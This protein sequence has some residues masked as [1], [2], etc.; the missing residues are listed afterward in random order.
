MLFHSD[1]LFSQSDAT[2]KEK[3]FQFSVTPGLGTN[4]MQPGSFS[5][6]ISINFTS[7]YSASTR[8]FEIGLVSN[9]NT[10]HTSG[11]QISGLANLTGANAFGGLSKK[12]KDMKLKNGFTS[13]LTGAQ[14]SGLTNIVVNDA[15]GAQFTGG[16]NLV[17]GLLL[18]TQISALSNIVYNYTFGVQAAGLFNVSVNSMD[19]VQISGLSNFTKGGLYGLQIGM[20]NQAGEMEGKNS[21]DNH[22]PTGIQF[23]LINFAKKMNGLQVGLINFAKR[24]QGT[25]IGLINFY[26]RGSQQ[27]TKDG[28]AIGLLN[29]GDFGYTSIYTN[30][31]F[32]LNYELATGTRK[33]TRI[34]LDSRNVYIENAL[35]YSRQAFHNDGWGIG[36]S[37]KKMFFNRSELLGATES[38]FYSYGLDIQHISLK[39]GEFNK[40]LSLLTRLKIM[41]GKRIAPKTFGINW[42]AAITYNAYWSNKLN[43][44]E[45]SSLS[46]ASSLGNAS[47]QHW[48]GF[49]VGLLMH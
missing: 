20:L 28:T 33:N 35:I 17:K 31:L 30:E 40:D 42:F 7:G 39:R 1:F 8:L 29:I 5:N 3:G 21:F 26:K 11:L 47:F 12:D 15:Y 16:I 27:G 23:G 49:S 43:Q 9:L 38:K 4:G 25:Q 14:I 24:S 19:G 34:K 6:Y 22:S 36:Y 46:H 32:G 37:L 45:P 13:L 48:P 44:L 10:N 18:G 2:I 41:V